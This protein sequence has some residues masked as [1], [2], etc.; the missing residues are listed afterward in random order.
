MIESSVCLCVFW[1]KFGNGYNGARHGFP[2]TDRR[3]HH[4]PVTGTTLCLVRE[5]VQDVC[6]HLM[7]ML[8]LCVWPPLLLSYFTLIVGLRLLVCVVLWLMPPRKTAVAFITNQLFGCQQVSFSRKPHIWSGRRGSLTLL[9]HTHTRT[10]THPHTAQCVIVQFL[11]R[12]VTFTPPH[13]P[14]LLMR[15]LLCNGTEPEAVSHKG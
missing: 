5:T 10:R 4:F 8:C 7:N 2:N 15:F 13:L 3:S 14:L 11:L 12:L 6:V 1:I 9:T